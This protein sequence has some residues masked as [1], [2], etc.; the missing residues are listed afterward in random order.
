MVGFIPEAELD[1]VL[2]RLA[3]PYRLYVPVSCAGR[4]ELGEWSPGIRP[5]LEGRAYGTAKQ[6]FLPR[7]EELFAFG[8]HPDG[9]PRVVQPER[10]RRPLALF[11]LRPCDARAIGMLDQV[12]LGQDPPDDPYRER[13]QG[14]LLMGLVCSRPGRA[15][16]CAQ[17]GGSPAGTAGLD[18][19][20]T[21]IGGGFCV[22]AVSTAGEAHAAQEDWPAATAAQV[23]GAREIQ[24]AAAPAAMAT[25]GLAQELEARFED[26]VWARLHEKCLGCAACTFFCP[27]CHCFDVMDAGSYDHGTRL[28]CWDS[29]MFPKFTLHA[30]GHNPR[31]SGKERMRQRVMHKFCYYPLRFG[32][33]ACVGCGRC[34][35]VCPVNL[36]IRAVLAELGGSE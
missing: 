26:E 7:S 3:G 32:P 11:G 1:R 9:T 15:C 2:A 21:R 14:A 12:F 18:L 24:Q 27:T 34:I 22:E 36:D 30:S 16:F 33:E 5:V 31:L 35:E 4:V 6:L 10:D 29:C 23:A 13:R 25:P 19:L 8:T 28:R 17:V 20:F